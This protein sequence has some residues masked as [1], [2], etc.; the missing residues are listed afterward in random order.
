MNTATLRHAFKEWAIV[1]KA[2]AE[3]KQAL[4]L[5]KG[6][7]AESGGEFRP[8]HERFWLYPTYMHEHEKGIKLEFLPWLPEVEQDR[9]LANR[10]R[11][12][13]FASVA[14]V[15]RIDRLEQAETLDDMH[16]WSA[17]TVRSRFH[18]RQPGL[19]VLSVR[20]YRVPSPFVL[21]E[22]AAY[23]GCKSWVELDDELPTGDATPVL[24]DANFVATCD[25]IRQ[26][27]LNPRK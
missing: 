5:R 22:T 8:E 17:D 3:G 24:G 4:I 27:L 26:R 20:V 21:M 2:L 9:P 25:Q 18:Y 23:A 1:C 15:F 14:E 12:M 16:I 7:I 19:Y 13:H 10:L 6:G 11:L